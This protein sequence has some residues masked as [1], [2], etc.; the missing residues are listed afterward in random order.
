MD[1]IQ[2]FQEL[3]GKRIS[4]LIINYQPYTDT[5]QTYPYHHSTNPSFETEFVD[6]MFDSIVFYAYEKD[7][8]EKEYNKGRFSNLRIAARN[9]YDLLAR[10]KKALLRCNRRQ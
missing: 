9:A 8:I 1:A 5:F 2:I 6:L 3:I 7:E 4:P 10:P